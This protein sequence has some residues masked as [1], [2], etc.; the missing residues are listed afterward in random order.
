MSRKSRSSIPI[1][2]GIDN[3]LRRSNIIHI[4]IVTSLKHS[5]V[6][7]IKSAT[8]VMPATILDCYVGNRERVRLREIV[9]I[10][11]GLPSRRMELTDWDD[12]NAKG[13]IGGER[14]VSSP[15]EEDSDRGACP[16]DQFGIGDWSR[17]D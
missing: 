5:T 6:D 14:C 8:A 3:S 1:T 17:G 4:S 15:D 16:L 7:A 2:S 9:S 12:S 13:Y 10:V 11:L